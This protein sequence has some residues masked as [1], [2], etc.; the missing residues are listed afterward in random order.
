MSPN[1]EIIQVQESEITNFKFGHEMVLLSAAY[2]HDIIWNIEH[3]T[4]HRILLEKY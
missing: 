3:G 4:D 1:Y 2:V